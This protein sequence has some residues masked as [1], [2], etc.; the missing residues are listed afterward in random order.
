MR[1][2]VALHG[3]TLITEPRSPGFGV[4]ASL[5]YGHEPGFPRRLDQQQ[6]AELDHLHQ[7]GR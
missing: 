7:V 1:E 3:G 4:R 6:P 2:R 5:P